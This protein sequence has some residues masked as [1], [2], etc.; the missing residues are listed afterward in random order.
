MLSVRASIS[1][2]A[3]LGILFAHGLTVSL[4]APIISMAATEDRGLS[5]FWVGWIVGSDDIVIFF[6]SLFAGYFVTLGNSLNY[7]IGGSISCAIA[8]FAFAGSNHIRNDSTFMIIC[9]SLRVLQGM[10]FAFSWTA[11]LLYILKQHPKKDAIISSI[12]EI[13][14]V[15]GVMLGPTLGNL[16][17]ALF[18]YSFPFELTGCLHITFSLIFVLSVEPLDVDENERSAFLDI[19]TLMWFYLSIPCQLICLQMLAASTF[20]GFCETILTIHFHD[21]MNFSVIEVS[22]LWSVIAVS[23]LVMVP[24]VVYLTDR[25]CFLMVPIAGSLLSIALFVLFLPYLIPKIPNTFFYESIYLFLSGGSSVSCL[26]PMYMAL[27]MLANQMGVTNSSTLISGVINATFA[28]GGIL[29]PVVFGGVIYEKAGFRLTGGL[30][31]LFVAIST[32]L[33]TCCLI[34]RRILVEL[35]C[36]DKGSDDENTTLV[37]TGSCS[38]GIDGDKKTG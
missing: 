14:I 16:F 29:G 23:Y 19:K 32:F 34:H 26:I 7:L 8:N 31:G 12:A 37:K 20:I 4:V 10:G 30:L 36:Q 11:G 24:L 3:F 13:I 6:V 28:M 1:I 18:G 38:G 27:T 25:K 5:T 35:C 9:F 2:A 21:E 17:Y 15:I 33:S 22:A